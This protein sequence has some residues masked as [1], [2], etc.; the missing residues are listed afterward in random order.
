[1]EEGSSDKRPRDDERSEVRVLIA[2]L[3]EEV[4]GQLISHHKVVGRDAAE[5]FMLLTFTMFTS[6]Q[7]PISLHVEHDLIVTEPGATLEG[8]GFEVHSL[9]LPIILAVQVRLSTVNENDIVEIISDLN[10]LLSLFEHDTS[11]IGYHLLNYLSGSKVLIDIVVE[12][13]A[14]SLDRLTQ[15]LLKQ[16][17]L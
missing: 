12:E 3:A 6:D 5:A 10:D 14:E 9:A 4:R 2:H 11:Q 1:M 15:H 7:I 16:L 13:E 8:D 17:S